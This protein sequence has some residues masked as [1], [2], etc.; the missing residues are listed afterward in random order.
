ME[1]SNHVDNIIAKASR[2][3]YLLKQLKRASIDRKSRIQFYCACIRSILENACQAFHSSLPAQPT[4]SVVMKQE[5]SVIVRWRDF[6][7]FR[8][9]Y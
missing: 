3:I 4:V 8:F 6:I 7:P 5:C 2:R 1:R 9:C